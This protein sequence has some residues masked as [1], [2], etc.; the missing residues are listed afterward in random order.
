MAPSRF[1]PTHQ[2]GR[3]SVLCDLSAVGARGRIFAAWCHG[4]GGR[5]G[6]GVGGLEGPLPVNLFGQSFIVMRHDGAVE[7]LIARE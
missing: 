7:P 5:S 2:A 6:G 4:R 3:R 1:G